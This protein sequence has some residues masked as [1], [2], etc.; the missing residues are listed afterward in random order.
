MMYA[1]RGIQLKDIEHIAARN[2]ELLN[3]DTFI[4][5]TT[6]GN[7]GLNIVK[8]LYDLDCQMTAEAYEYPI[9]HG[10]LE[11]IKLLHNIGCQ[12]NGNITNWINDCF[13]KSVKNWYYNSLLFLDVEYYNHNYVDLY[14]GMERY[15]PY[16]TD[17]DVDS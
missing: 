13:S 3:S 16:D 14:E 12:V 7:F 11:M 15:N 9:E 10:Q 2:P 6:M 8:L 4:I 5:A 1:I 17:S